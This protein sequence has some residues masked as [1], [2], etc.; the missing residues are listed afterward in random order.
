MG[1]CRVGQPVRKSERLPKRE[2]Q[3]I[4]LDLDLPEC[5]AQCESERQRVPVAQRE[6]VGQ[7]VGVLLALPVAVRVGFWF[8]QCVPLGFALGEP[9]CFSKRERVGLLQPVPVPEREPI[10]IAE[11]ES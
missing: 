3:R 9:V 10:R 1:W 2:S 8:P 5:F 11:R 6:P 4:A 7:R